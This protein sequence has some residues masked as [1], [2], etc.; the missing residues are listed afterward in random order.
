MKLCTLSLSANL[1][2]VAIPMKFGIW[3]FPC[4]VN[5]WYSFGQCFFSKIGLD[6]AYYIKMRNIETLLKNFTLINFAARSTFLV[7]LCLN[8]VG[9]IYHQWSIYYMLNLKKLRFSPK[10]QT[11]S[12]RC[13]HIYF[14]PDILLPKLV[15]NC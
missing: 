5:I 10:Y 9:T 15:G 11:Y 13:K 2:F 4:L 6:L 14:R 7:Q 3:N 8:Y 1:V 12:I